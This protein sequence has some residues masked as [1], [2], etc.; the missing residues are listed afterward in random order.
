M[1]GKQEEKQVQEE[2]QGLGQ[3]VYGWLQAVVPVVVGIVVVFTLLGRITVVDGSSML[4]TLE[5]GDRMLLWSLGYEPQQGDI[6]VL[7]KDFEG[8]SGPIVKRVI[9]VE[10]QTV[11]IDYEENTVYV[12]GTPLEEDYIL[13]PTERQ[14]WQEIDHITVPEGCIFV[15]G[16]NRNVSNDSRNPDLGVVDTRY[17]LGKCCLVIWPL[18]R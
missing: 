9:A 4:P 1:A 13:E 18:G 8:V 15:M 17:V 6:V 5:H 12:D 2:P 10:G 14:Y 16:D 11:D 7:H 3:M